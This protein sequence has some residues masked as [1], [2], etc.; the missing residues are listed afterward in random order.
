MESIP[1]I[2]EMVQYGVIG[3]AI[4]LIAAMCYETKLFVSALLRM[5]EKIDTL[6]NTIAT[7]TTKVELLTFSAR[8]AEQSAIRNS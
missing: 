2:P 7:L 5:T 3:I 1:I 4:A 6:N 8:S